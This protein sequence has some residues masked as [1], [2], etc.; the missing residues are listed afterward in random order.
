MAKKVKGK[1]GKKR[2]VGPE[3]LTT[4]HIIDER[5]KMLCPRLGDIYNRTAVVEGILEVI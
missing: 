3:P 1:K 5:A 2:E 4:I